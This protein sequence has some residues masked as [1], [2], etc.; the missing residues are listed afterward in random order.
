MHPVV[1]G[2]YVPL[3]DYIP[4]LY[5]L[6]PLSGGLTAGEGPEV[7]H[8]GKARV[9]PNICYETVM[10]HLI[11]DQ[12]AALGAAGKEPD[13]LVTQTNDG[14]Y[15][16]TSALDMHMVCSVFRAVECRKPMFLAANT[17]ISAV[18]DGNGVIRGRLAPGEE[19]FLIVNGESRGPGDGKHLVPNVRLDGR[20]SPYV[21]FGDTL[22]IASAGACLLLLAVGLT[23]RFRRPS[24]R[25]TA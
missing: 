10:P 2:E 5:A 7:F 12:V 13:V 6:T 19:S 18:I 25:A 22:G 20:V 16:G 14:W 11:R 24:P 1:F 9:A 17:G 8:V 23:D 4:A 3:G 15:R 21:R